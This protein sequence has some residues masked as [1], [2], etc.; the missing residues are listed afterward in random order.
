MPSLPSQ[1]QM[2]PM[3]KPLL[4]PLLLHALSQKQSSRLMSRMAKLK[5]SSTTLSIHWLE[6]SAHG[7]TRGPYPLLM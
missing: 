6:V 5:P 4:Q 7:S 3:L 1:Q 2:G